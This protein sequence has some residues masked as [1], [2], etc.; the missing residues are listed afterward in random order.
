MKELIALLLTG[1][2][3]LAGVPAFAAKGDA[4]K[5][6][7]EIRKTSKD[8]LAQLYKQQPSAKKAV[9]SAAGYAVFSN[10]GMKIFVAGSGSGKGVAVNAKSKKEV[11]MKMIE[12][13]AGLGLGV[14]TF[15][16]VFVFENEKGW[17][18]F[19]NSGWE[20]GTQ[21]TAAAKSGDSGAA[22]QGAISVAPGVWLY[23]MTD[24]G[25]AVEATVKGTKY[26]K[27]D[28]LN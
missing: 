25:L 5:A 8:I 20:A 12:V 16:L 3:M 24:K 22:Y 27:D 21:A 7:A 15:R 18:N 13:Q 9:A 1:I 19:V 26:Y 6:R 28:D 14:K 4:D 10:F 11:F 23:Q 2:V 17:N